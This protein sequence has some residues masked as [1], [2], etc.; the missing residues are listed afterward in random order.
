MSPKT[1]K[2]LWVF[3]SVIGIVAMLF[4]T[5]MPVFY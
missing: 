5:I 4:F 3:I 1:A 2:R